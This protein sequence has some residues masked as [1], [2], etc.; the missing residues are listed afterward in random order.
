MDDPAANAPGTAARPSAGYIPTLDGWRAVAILLV[1]ID[2]AFNSYNDSHGGG[3]RHL[4]LGD[5]GVA[6]F[7]GISGL[8]ITS[9]LLEEWTRRGGVSLRAFYIRRAFRILPPAVLYLAVLAALGA[10]GLLLVTRL[11]LL[12]SLF[13]F[14]NYLPVFFA[15]DGA[16]FYTSH[17]WSL[18]VEEHFYLFWPGLLVLV[19]RKRAL[20]VA[21]AL[22]LGVAYWR[23]IEATREIETLGRILPTYYTRTDLRLDA[24][25]WG[26]AAALAVDRPAVRAFFTKYLNAGVW[27][28]ALAAYIAVIMK[29][30]AR[31]TIWEGILVPVLLL[32][33]VLRPAQGAAP[34]FETAIPRWIGRISYSLYLWQLFF[35]LAMVPHTLG[36]LQSFP[37][38]VV[39]LFA[40]AAGSYYF[41]ERPMIRLG[42]R[43]AAPATPGHADLAVPGAPG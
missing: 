7:F 35:P 26:A 4:T 12:S 34:I 1:I 16:G 36:V 40:C 30:G 11:E 27:A 8:L 37:V 29:Y 25:M 42:H 28:L 32:G 17:F 15:P 24:L 14:R 19:G 39:A 13:F 43:L 31:P 18:A 22:C 41:V 9:R 3:A 21:I 6:I 10:L 5:H 23:S 33:T 38:N 20:P 2:H